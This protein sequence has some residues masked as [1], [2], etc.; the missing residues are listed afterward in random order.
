M[1]L[2]RSPRVRR[3]SATASCAKAGALATRPPCRRS[4]SAELSAELAACHRPSSRDRAL[5]ARPARLRQVAL[6]LGLPPLQPACFRAR[7]I[8]VHQSCTSQV[9]SSPSL[10]A[11]HT[12][13]Q[14]SSRAPPRG[15]G[16][17]AAADAAARTPTPPPQRA[18]LEARRRGGGSVRDQNDWCV[19]TPAEARSLSHARMLA[20][21]PARPFARSPPC[22]LAGTTLHARHQHHHQLEAPHGAQQPARPCSRHTRTKAGR[23]QGEHKGG[24][25]HSSTLHLARKKYSTK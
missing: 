7:W 3:A 25:Q 20:R 8:R 12:L 17:C 21:A 16:P 6:V 1:K 10:H 15:R 4:G 22:A 11:P 9:R 2:P 18:P 14:L 23:G 24:K 5:S 13:G 19:C